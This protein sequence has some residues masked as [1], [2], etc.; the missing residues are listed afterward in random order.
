MTKGYGTSEKKG[1]C[2]GAF[3]P[4]PGTADNAFPYS[5]GFCF[6]CFLLSG[7]IG[8]LFPPIVGVDKGGEAPLRKVLF[9]PQLVFV[10]FFVFYLLGVDKGGLPPY[11]YI[12]DRRS[13]CFAAADDNEN[14]IQYNK[15]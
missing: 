13:C 4:P 2:K 15:S 6:L 8:G 1:V 3:F 12:Q 9:L 10:L 14:G 11:C 5:V 7:V